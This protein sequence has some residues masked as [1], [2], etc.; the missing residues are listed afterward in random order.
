MQ[1]KHNF[2]FA[3]QNYHRRISARYE[4]F[5]F[6]SNLQIELKF[7]ITLWA[8]RKEDAGIFLA[9]RCFSI[10]LLDVEHYTLTG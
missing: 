8:L 5:M 4:L 3:K 7:L 1:T 2:N 10:I 9:S 6:K